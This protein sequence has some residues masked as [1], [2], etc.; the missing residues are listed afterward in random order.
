MEPALTP[1]LAARRGTLVTTLRGQVYQC[2]PSRN[3]A[4]GPA[5]ACA[6]N[7][8]GGPSD[9]P[10]CYACQPGYFMAFGSC[11]PCLSSGAMVVV[12]ISVLVLWFLVNTFVYRNVSF[13]GP[14]R[15]T[16]CPGLARRSLLFGAMA[17]ARRL[18][19]QWVLHG[20]RARKAGP[21]AL[22][23]APC[24]DTCVR[25]ILPLCLSPFC[26]RPCG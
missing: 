22:Q 26:C 3:C 8:G 6:S 19:Y 1:R 25:L 23:S 14:P 18:A 13:S 21:Q 5:S 16:A 12:Y 24:P 7:F 20:H 9:G 15:P 11:Q 17:F 10:L 2:N 4:G